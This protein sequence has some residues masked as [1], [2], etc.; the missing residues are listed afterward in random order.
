M[1]VG[2]Q[3]RIDIPSEDVWLTDF[4]LAVERGET[5]CQQGH[6][7]VGRVDEPFQ[8]R[9]AFKNRFDEI[10]PSKIIEKPDEEVQREQHQYS[11]AGQSE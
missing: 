10:P 5:Y 1:E 4:V 6:I 8:L 2:A 9:I 11:D 3:P 7:D